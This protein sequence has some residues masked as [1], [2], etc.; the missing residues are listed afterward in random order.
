[1]DSPAA[2]TFWK[3]KYSF[4]EPGRLLKLDAKAAP[5]SPESRE[6]DRVTI[7]ARRGY[8]PLRQKVVTVCYGFPAAKG[9]LR[10]WLP[11]AQV[12]VGI[13]LEK[14]FTITVHA[15][16]SDAIHP[17]VS[18]IHLCADARDFCGD[19]SPERMPLRG[20]ECV[21]ERSVCSF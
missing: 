14:R 11:D 13:E 19:A 17:L 8:G 20:A 6:Q 5:E 16:D 2:S 12:Q 18:G 15:R 21:A 1:M 4:R 10:Q 7:S 3:S 9:K